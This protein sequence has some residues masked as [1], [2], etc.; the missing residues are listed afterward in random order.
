M[1]LILPPKNLEAE[2]SL[3]GCLLLKGSLFDITEDAGLLADDFY[4]IKHQ[5]IFKAITDL[6]TAGATPDIVTVSDKLSS[7]NLMDRTGGIQYLADL[8]EKT[9]VSSESALRDYAN[10]IKEKSLH[11]QFITICGDGE[12]KAY[13]QEESFD[14]VIDKTT[15]QLIE[16]MNSRQV[17][18]IKHIRELVDA[19]L[20]E[21]K[22]RIE[23]N[24]T[25]IGISS[26]FP[27]LDS[28]VGGFKPGDMIV[29]A[30]RPGM[31]KTSLALNMA[32]EMAK[33]D[34][35]VAF[36]SLEMPGSQLINRIIATECGINSKNFMTGRLEKD[37]FTR[38]W[39]N[40]DSISKLPIYIDDTSTM[41]M[42]DVRSKAKKIRKEAGR[43]DVIFIDYLQLVGSNVHKDDRV[44]QV[45]HI[46]RTIK[47]FAK[48]MRM[49]IIA[50]AQL[51][52]KVEDRTTKIPMLS[53][54]R[55]SGAIE[56]DADLVMFIHREDVYN[57]ET[58]KKGTAE[59]YIQKN[60]HGSTGSVPLS[61]IAKYTKF[62][63][64]DTNAG[65]D[66]NI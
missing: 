24:K 35:V 56:Q 40:I 36:F 58:E 50:L 46:S 41:T 6:F 30:G 28:L 48:D 39:H 21:L 19:E 66:Y 64:L 4:E 10:I 65:E 34:N 29:L 52:R 37:E 31:G 18:S 43:L 49:P 11:R 5:L 12:D 16:L 42:S 14:E 33:L 9:P 32:I 38:L 15:S 3:L 51:S 13:K 17:S 44:R 54:L 7:G 47:L 26:G 23:S 53:D 20:A 2:A 59:I 45:E 55:D 61:F 1:S 60:R 57:K 25:I 27:M 22:K 8:A 62:A 63:S